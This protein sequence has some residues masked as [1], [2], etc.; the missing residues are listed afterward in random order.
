MS[1]Q[2][3]RQNVVS[4]LGL[5]EHQS[6]KYKEF[7]KGKR[8]NTESTDQKNKNG[9]NSE[10]RSSRGLP[11]QLFI[12][13]FA[14]RKY[15]KNQGCGVT[16]SSLKSPTSPAAIGKIGLSSINRIKETVSLARSSNETN[17][18]NFKQNVNLLDSLET[19]KF[20]GSIDS[21]R[22]SDNLRCAKQQS[23]MRTS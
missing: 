20:E 22:Q 12:D 6:S 14:Q 23:Q 18:P 2:N 13:D 3:I 5:S 4:H 16:A 10:G 19:N 7:I 8:K 17:S 1:E 21:R 15:V 9:P 11:A